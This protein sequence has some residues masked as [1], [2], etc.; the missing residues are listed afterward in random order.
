MAVNQKAKLLALREILL[1]ESDEEHP[2]SA[3]RM[4]E[5]LARQGI[6]AERKSVYADIEALREA[7]MDIVRSGE[8]RGSGYFVASR[9]FELAELKLLVDSVQSSKFITARKTRALIGKL[10]GLTSR[11]EARSLSRQVYVTGRVKTMNESIYYNVDELHRA[12]AADRQIRFHYF[13]YTAQ[14]KRQY[15]REGQFYQVSPFALI[16][17]SENYY[18]LA[19]DAG[20]GILK[21]Y[22]V[23]KMTDIAL[24]GEPRQGRET[25]E[26]QDMSAYTRKVF[27]MFSGREARVQLRFEN[28]LAGPVLD[29]LGTDAMLIPDGEAH[30]TVLAD[31]VVSPQFYAGS[32]ALGTGCRSSRPSGP[33]RATRST[34]GGSQHSM[35]HEK[36]PPGF[37]RRFRLVLNGDAVDDGLGL[38]GDGAV[39]VRGLSVGTDGIHH[40]H[41]LRHVAEGGVIAVQE[42]AVRLAD[43]ELA[44]GAVGVRGPGHGDGAPG[45][46]DGV[47]AAV[48]AELAGDGLVRAAGAVAV[49]VAALHHEAVHDP[50]E[51]EAVV[52]AI[53]RQL[54]EVGHGEGGAVAVQ[55][56]GDGAVIRDVD[57]GGVLADGLRRA[58]GGAGIALGLAA[59]REAQAEHGCQGENE[60]FH[61]VPPFPPGL[62]GNCSQD[63][64]AGG[65]GQ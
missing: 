39:V 27:G 54:H 30:F 17:E 60:F 5:L 23:D 41:A 46:G 47:V 15:R 43:E 9:R 65:R 10:E 48:G 4:V 63:T 3:G 26:A 34:S 61:G 2:L 14:R 32:A 8:G 42:G 11:Y 57:D 35:K 53:L 38:R 18:L 22:R 49:G 52:E 45:V 62:A 64:T 7:G 24:T 31:V 58:A 13:E 25:F 44:A 51:G 6:E 20:S 50:V 16:W 12:I 56:Q 55:L 29:R 36:P 28:R 37:R 40:V 59:G 33:R 21:H 1:R 19:Y